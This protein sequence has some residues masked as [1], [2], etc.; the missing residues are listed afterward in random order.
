MLG[1]IDQFSSVGDESRL[2]TSDVPQFI[3]LKKCLRESG[4]VAPAASGIVHTEV[5][6]CFDSLVVKLHQFVKDSALLKPVAKTEMQ[7]LFSASLV[8]DTLL[9][10]D[11]NFSSLAFYSL[12]NS[13]LL[14]K[15]SFSHLSS[16]VFGVCFSHSDPTQYNVRIFLPSFEIWLHFYDWTEIIDLLYAYSHKMPKAEAMDASSKNSVKGTVK[17]TETST[18]APSL[19]PRQDSSVSLLNR[20]CNTKEDTDVLTLRSED[21]GITVYFPVCI[22]GETM[23]EYCV[24]DI[25]EEGHQNVSNSCVEQKHSKNISIS[26]HSKSCEIILAGKNIK[27]KATFDK[28]S[29]LVGVCEGSS[30]K[31]WPF[32]QIFQ[33]DVET[34]ICMDLQDLVPTT[35]DVLCHRI[36]V[37]LSHR[38]LYF[39]HTV[40]FDFPEAGSSEPALPCMDFKI[41]LRKTSLLISDGRVYFQLSTPA[42]ICL[43]HLHHELCMSSAITL[44]L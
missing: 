17:M 8:N 44:T 16:S 15:C 1:V 23:E 36:D 35:V 4:K 29:G 24:A 21:V 33:V 42:Y 19:S 20:S 13:V 11:A 7:L 39:W 26:T 37:W 41:Q 6:C 2:F 32:F 34:D 43:L 3:Q 18:V 38:I 5:R 40:V 28:T 10:M 14:A 22:N 27:I 9:N 30:I 31:S 25:D 12:L